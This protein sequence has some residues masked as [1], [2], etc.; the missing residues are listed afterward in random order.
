MAYDNSQH[1]HPGKHDPSTEQI[2][3]KLKTPPPRHPVASHEGVASVGAPGIKPTQH[4]CDCGPNAAANAE[5][6]QATKGPNE[7]PNVVM[8][9]GR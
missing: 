7:R 6:N 4:P 1:L 3:A 9:P 2:K 8:I 5:F